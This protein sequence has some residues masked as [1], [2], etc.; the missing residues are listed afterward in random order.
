MRTSQKNK[1]LNFFYKT[2][3]IIRFGIQ[4]IIKIKKETKW[5]INKAAV[6]AD[7][8]VAEDMAGDR[9]RCTRRFVRTARKN[10]MSRLSQVETARYTARN[11]SQNV[12]IADVNRQRLT[13]TRINL[14]LF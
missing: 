13:F 6:V 1:Y 10:A 7:M 2:P 9:R 5:D 14:P 12:K 4:I 3:K 11:A 8:A